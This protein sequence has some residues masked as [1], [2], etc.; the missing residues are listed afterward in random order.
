VY[1]ATF[2]VHFRL[3]Q[4]QFDRTAAIPLFTKMARLHVRMAQANHS[5][6]SVVHPAA[7]PWYTWPIMKHPIALWQDTESVELSPRHVILLG[8]PAV[9]WG[10]LIV[11]GIAVIRFARRRD[12]FSRDR[13]AVAFLSGG[14]LINYVP[15]IGIRR[16]MYLYHYLFALVFAIMLAA[17]CGGTLA[18][19]ND[20]R[21]GRLWTFPSRRSAMVYW[22]VAALVLV[23]FIYFLPLTYGWPL[24]RES[25][26]QHFWV[27]HPTF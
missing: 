21:D 7:S 19:W 1:V 8:N 4:P 3:G 5:L 26:D 9:W 20:D 24:S 16:V 10:A 18:G 6:E 12:L 22:S 2:A 23:G 27:L 17:Y 25:Y 14:L 13:F 11:I 15:F